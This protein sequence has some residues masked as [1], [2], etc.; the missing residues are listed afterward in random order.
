MTGLARNNSPRFD[1][2]SIFLSILLNISIFFKF[3]LEQ[4]NLI[5]KLKAGPQN[6]VIKGL[7]GT[8]KTIC[9]LSAV[10][11]K[12]GSTLFVCVTVSL[13]EWAR[14]YAFLFFFFTMSV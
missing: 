1:F 2:L 11:D 14:R 13:R 3:S 6:I 9:A 4:F 10:H 8:G 12:R 7:A 5:Q